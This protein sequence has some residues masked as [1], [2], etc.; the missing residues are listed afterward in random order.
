M[1]A[2]DA[3]APPPYAPAIAP[4]PFGCAL[5]ARVVLCSLRGVDHYYVSCP[6][7]RAPGPEYPNQEQAIARW[8]AS[9]QAELA[10]VAAIWAIAACLA[11]R[12]VFTM[13]GS[14]AIQLAAGAVEAN[15]APVVAARII[16][17]LEGAE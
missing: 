5:P 3:A 14:T 1:T 16:A 12:R 11:K 13:T 8:N 17:A 6:A 9:Q 7:C 2:E 15:A 10:L 4:C